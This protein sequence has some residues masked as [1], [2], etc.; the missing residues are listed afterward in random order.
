MNFD[1]IYMEL[2]DSISAGYEFRV[3][4]WIG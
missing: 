4:P 1:G 3:A 2:A